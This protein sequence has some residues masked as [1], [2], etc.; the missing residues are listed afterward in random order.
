MDTNDSQPSAIT[1]AAVITGVALLLGVLFD[2]FFYG[3]F[4]G[5]AFP[6]YVALIITTFFVLILFC[7]Q[8]LHP[9]ALWLAPPLL[10]F[11]IMVFVRTSEPLTLLN[12]FASL[13]LLILMAEVS[14][15]D[16]L[17]NFSINDY[18]KA[19]PQAGFHF[20]PPFFRTL[21][22]LLP[23]RKQSDGKNI[24]SPVIKGILM[25]IPVLII[26]LLLFA[27][28]DLIF[29]KYLSSFISFD[30]ESETIFRVILVLLIT[31]GF[32][33]AYAYALSQK[34]Q[35][36]ATHPESAPGRF[37]HIESSILLGSVSG[38]FFIFILVQLTY[39]FGGESNISA[40]G[41]T[42]AEY[43]RRGFFE[44]IAVAILSFL[45]LLLIEKY[46]VKKEAAHSR[47]FKVLS[48][49]LVIEVL[50]IMASA[51]TRLSLYE[52]AYGLT[53]LRLYSHAFIILLAVVFCL[54]LYK[55]YRHGQDTVFAL[56][57]F[58]SLM[59]FL[60]VMNILNP[61]ALIA[62]RNIALF[63]ATGILDTAY[64]S[65]LSDDALPVAIQL[66]ETSNAE[67]RNSFGSALYQRVQRRLELP[68]TSQ[69]NSAGWQSLNIS[70]L[71]AEKIIRSQLP[72]LQQY[73]D[74]Q[75]QDGAAV[76]LY[77]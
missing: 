8:H 4:L 13:L 20:I 7:K 26:F 6:L 77:P 10:F 65:S 43:A 50:I 40:Q 36:N 67:I 64:L 35:G 39:L 70:R 73:R 34:S 61:D 23:F 27:S 11:S 15:R 45:L 28:A 22:D 32:T 55:I 2:Y 37:G 24:L 18:L 46:I 54:L 66:L 1:K 59:L 30:F 44:L 63:P 21:S 75:P 41:F 48:G 3:K 12:L 56:Q 17:K 49:V 53:T 16:R 60:V 29:Q 76:I 14:I 58:I 25:A 71:V 72:K 38:L 62:R 68:Q 69:W 74:Y 19:L 9:E 52:N 47:G 31:C 57:L 42:Y 51:F 33:G 5:I